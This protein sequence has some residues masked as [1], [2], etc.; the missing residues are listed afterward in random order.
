M[1]T[2]NSQSQSGL[3]ALLS[4]GAL[5]GGTPG[6]FTPIAELNDIPF[7]FAKW[8]TTPT[9][10]FQSTIESAGKTIPG[11]TI[12]EVKGNRV[13]SDAGQMA[14][15]AA[16]AAQGAY[17]FKLLFPKNPNLATPQATT[18]DSFAF[19]A[20]VLGVKFGLKPDGT[21]ET[22]ISLQFDT[23]PVETVGA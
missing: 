11:I 13:G 21:I 17:D 7:E 15:M 1:S 18:G 19:S 14:V 12:I 10:H 9:T 8:K 3:G 6:T 23:L 2:Q 5:S 16:Y 20:K 22:S 4:I